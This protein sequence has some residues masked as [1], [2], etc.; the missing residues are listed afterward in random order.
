METFPSSITLGTYGPLF[1]KHVTLG[2]ASYVYVFNQTENKRWCRW[3]GGLNAAVERQLKK[4]TFAVLYVRWNFFMSLGD[5]CGCTRHEN[6]FSL[7]L[8]QFCFTLQV[9]RKTCPIII[10]LKKHKIKSNSFPSTVH[11]NQKVCKNFSPRREQES[12]SFSFAVKNRTQNH[13]NR[14]HQ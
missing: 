7:L 10:A 9:K 13:F 2:I 4:K 1:N 14:N 12:K 11:K 5:E 6:C 8:K 3:R